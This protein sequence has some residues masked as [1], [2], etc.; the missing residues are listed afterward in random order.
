MLD[1]YVIMVLRKDGFL[2]KTTIDR[3]STLKLKT[4]MH[5]DH[6]YLFV[7]TE[8]TYLRKYP[9]VDWRSPIALIHWFMKTRPHRGLLSYLEPDDFKKWNF[10]TG[11]EI[12]TEPMK[13]GLTPKLLEATTVRGSIIDPITFQKLALSNIYRNHIRKVRFGSTNIALLLIGLGIVFVVVLILMT[14][15]EW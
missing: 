1:E 3:A 8:A 14:Q 9:K 12:P 7:P 6:R 4:F 2:Y 15:V 5:N 11:E 10:E 13:G